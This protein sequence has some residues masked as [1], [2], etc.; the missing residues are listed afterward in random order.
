MD[1]DLDV[2]NVVEMIFKGRGVRTSYIPLL[3][4]DTRCAS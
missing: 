4:G 2:R 3:G 1:L